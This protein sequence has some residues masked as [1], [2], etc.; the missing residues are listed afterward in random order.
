[1]T[2]EV[3]IARRGLGAVHDELRNAGLNP[4]EALTEVAATLTGR[5]KVEGNSRLPATAIERL[6]TLS[7][8]VVDGALLANLYQEFLLSEAEKW[9]R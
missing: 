4:I 7:D 5:L 8:V 1:M 9:P 3:A 6:L 2:D